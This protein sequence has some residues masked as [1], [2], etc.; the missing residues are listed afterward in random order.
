M[1][2]LSATELTKSYGT[3]VILDRVSFHINEGDR[4]G[5][6]GANGAGKTTLLN[7]LTGNDTADGGEFFVSRDLTVGYLRQKDDFREDSTLASE[8]ERIYGHFHEME[9]EIRR[10]SDEVAALAE[11][12]AGV[13]AGPS[14]KAASADYTRALERL[15]VLQDRYRDE[16]GFTY[17]SEMNGIL[18]SMAFGPEY[19]D[20]KIS[21]LSGGERTRLALACLLME[22]PDMLLLDEPTN[23]L[24][25][26]MLKW[27]EQFLKNYKGTLVM[28]SHDRYFLDQMATRIFDL[29]HRRL[30]TY[31]GNYTAFAEKKRA[32]READLRAYNK[33]R[34]EIRRQ[35]D[36][37]RR[38]KERGTEH[39]AKRAASREKRLAQID[40]LDK[41]EAEL[42]KIRIQF[43]QNY[44]SGSDV[45][46]AEDLS[47]SFGFGASR[48][49][50]FAGVHFDIKRGERICIVGPNGVGKTTLLR[51]MM[52][53]LR[54][55]TG[56]IRHGHNLEFGYYDQRQAMLDNSK[57]VMEEVHDTFRLYKDSEIRAI[58]GRFL[59]TGEQVF[60]QVG[61]LSGGEKARL[62]L[63]KLMMSGANVL[64][65]DEPTN[66]LDID[67]KEVF[68]E[69]LAE[70]PGT[71]IAVSH[72][73]YF[74][75]RVA[76][77]IFELERSGITEYVGGYDYYEEK[78][79]QI[80]SAK[81]YAAELSGTKPA[82]G[83]PAPHDGST[84]SAGKP[85]GEEALVADIRRAQT[86]AGLAGTDET[87]KAL[88]AAEERAL[89]K[90][91]QTEEKRLARK[92]AQLEEEIASL[93]EEIEDL[94]QE[95]CQ[96]EVLADP[97]RLNELDEEV[98]A[99]K[100]E[101]EHVY[102]E[103]MEL[104]E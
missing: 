17:K 95:M 83:A 88:S 20:K 55:D 42:G 16:G 90:K 92:K 58:L 32:Q 39:L 62:A 25:I 99:T 97:K 60:L 85:S 57:T 26:G 64:V 71:V 86:S 91:K 96:P 11:G 63:L 2:V 61:D 84:A 27:L 41:P 72:D 37:I 19:Y 22:H 89:K 6:V 38:F 78:K 50:L 73:R 100:E 68:E 65:L 51:M 56:F 35:E 12:T 80:S 48:K 82:A 98:K 44:Q 46:L 18:T 7:I 75:N 1:I 40:R 49:E 101:L 54:A 59:F 102:E 67:S 33:Q 79:A 13:T 3:D 14:E 21:T 77:R 23:H 47:K 52:G 74:L 69:A 29:E 70:Y 104:E 4:I 45:L 53:D 30:K 10:L 94:Q 36:M 103:W 24:D 43:K 81:R 66:H 93:E 87:G 76:T 8:V 5:I 28:V 9:D 34:E 15:G 31:N